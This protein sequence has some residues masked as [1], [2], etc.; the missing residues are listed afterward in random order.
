MICDEN[1]LKRKETEWKK[2][3]SVTDGKVLKPMTRSEITSEP[4]F[5]I[6]KP[7]SKDSLHAKIKDGSLFGYVQ[8]D[9]VVP[10][11]LK[12]K[13]ASFPP[14]FK[15]TKVGRNDLETT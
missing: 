14:N 7:L 4:T 8:C 5:P 15:K 12:S 9:L 2:C 11:E 6:K 13:F 3:G 10:D 1:T